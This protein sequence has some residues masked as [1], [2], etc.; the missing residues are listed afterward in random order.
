LKNLKNKSISFFVLLVALFLTACGNQTP[1]TYTEPYEAALVPE[2]ISPL[3]ILPS[4]ADI[5]HE[6]ELCEFCY[7]HDLRM[8]ESVPPLNMREVYR[9]FGIG[10]HFTYQFE[11]V[12]EAT[13]L[14][15]DAELPS[16]IAIWPDTTLRDFSFVSL[17]H[18]GRGNLMFNFYVREVLLHIDEL[19]PRDVVL[20]TV[21][22][23]HYFI[24]RGGIEFTDENGVRQRMFIFEN[25]VGGCH[26]RYTLSAPYVEWIHPGDWD[27]YALYGMGDVN[28]MYG[29]EAVL[30]A[31][32]EF[33]RSGFTV[34]NNDLIA[35]SYFVFNN[36]L[37]A[38]Q[39]SWN[40][41]QRPHIMYAFHDMTG[42]G[43]PE[44]FVGGGYALIAVYTLHN[45]I[46]VPFI[47]ER[48]WHMW[49]SLLKNIYGEYI[50][51]VN[52]GRMGI[53][54]NEFFA[55]DENGNSLHVGGI[56]SWERAVWCDDYID[57]DFI[58]EFYQYY[59]ERLSGNSVQITEDEYTAL[60]VQWGIYNN[61]GRVELPWEYL[62]QPTTF[63]TTKRIHETMP[64][65]TFKRILGD[66]VEPQN[67]EMIEQERYITIT[68]L[69]ENGNLLQEIDGII[70]GGHA[71]WMVAEHDSFQLQFDDFNFD[72]YLDMWLYSAINHGTA[73]GAWAHFWL[74]DNELMQFIKS[75]ELSEV[76]C[77]A[78]LGANHETGQIEVSSRGSGG[79]PW[80]TDYYEWINSELVIVHS[81]L[82]EYVW[83]NFIPSYQV[84]TRHN[85]LTGETTREY[86]PPESA[87]AHSITK[88]ID[89]NPDMEFPTHEITLAMWRL[90]EDSKYKIHS[91]Q[92]E[93]EISISGKRRFDS[94]VSQVWQTIRGLRAGYGEGRWIS[95]DPENPLNLHFADFTG[96][97]YL[98][99]SLRRFP[100]GTGHMA[101]DPHYFWLFNPQATSL[102]NAFER[103][104]SLEAAAAPGQVMRV[105]DGIVEIFSFHGLQS[106]Y[107]TTYAYVDGEFV[108]VSTENVSPSLD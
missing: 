35:P 92:Y 16:T 30:N 73:G 52:S 58:F 9:P 25:M 33:E 97:G 38:T 28:L 104:Y 49:L 64:E 45:D 23:E 95:P 84:T 79:G 89:I 24:P 37:A 4:M 36:Y 72:G 20:L 51:R 69:D 94:G 70:Q 53:E 83:R 66:F 60:L 5:S 98:D 14:Q 63:T 90:P 74:W 12:H 44:L 43:M 1:E 8:P 46:A 101:D 80:A 76:S 62:V 13:Y 106:H 75:E 55:L 82:I 61:A 99:M 27:L 77:M 17:G 102:W 3:E 87:P 6:H 34:R 105:G 7:F 50:I 100:P 78:W 41:E 11:T 108:F 21:A 15:W 26:P 68:I 42:N 31:Y 85:Y 47:Y 86:Y 65:F 56:S 96:N 22:F 2:E 40:S 71:D 67:I 29:F 59:G 93:I 18:D 48:T 10:I 81:V 19:S 32:A 91:Y 88:T 103:N 39:N 107:L 54:W 57:Y